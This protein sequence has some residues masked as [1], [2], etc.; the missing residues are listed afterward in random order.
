[1]QEKY[2]TV[3]GKGFGPEVLGDILRSCHFGCTLDPDN[4]VVVAEHNVAITILAK[5][6]VFSMGT[7][8]AVINALLT[9]V[10]EKEKEE[11]KDEETVDSLKY[12][13]EPWIG[14]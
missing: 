2:R 5:M 11:K 6:G 12:G 13:L 7:Q 8:N 3:F 9:V 1:M 4:L 14:E 10:P